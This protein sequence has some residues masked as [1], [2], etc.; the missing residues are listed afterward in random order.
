MTPSHAD[1]LSGAE[2]VEAG[3]EGDRDLDFGGRGLW[4]IPKPTSP[5]SSPASTITGST[6]ST[7]CCLGTGNRSEIRPPQPEWRSL[8][9]GYDKRAG[10]G[11]V[12]ARVAMRGSV[13]RPAI[14]WG[15]IQPAASP[16]PIRRDRAWHRCP[17]LARHRR[18]ILAEN[19]RVW[20]THFFRLYHCALAALRWRAVRNP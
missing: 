13:T 14:R 19:R 7:N 5:T 3:Y 2:G 9:G 4:L 16:P 18:P 6:G 12:Q 15:Q 8:S 11:I 17:T 1:D 20:M 10:R